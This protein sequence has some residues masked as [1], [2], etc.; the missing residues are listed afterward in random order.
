[1]LI[2]P[3]SRGEHFDGVGTINAVR[4]LLEYGWDK[5][6]PPLTHARRVLFRL[7]A[8]DDDPDYLFEFGGKGTIDEDLARRARAILREAAAAALAQAGYEGDPRL[9][10]AARRIIERVVALSALAAR[11]E[12]VRS[13]RQSARARR[14]GRAAVGLCCCSCS[15]T[16][17]SFA[18]SI[19]TRWRCSTTT[20]R[21]RS[22]DRKAM[23]LVRQEVV[24]QPHLVLGDMLPNRNAA[25][26]DVVFADH[27]ARADGA[28][29]LSP[30]E[31]QLVQAVRAVPRRPRRA[32]RL[33]SAQRHVGR[34]Q[35]ESVPLA[36]VS[37]RGSSRAATSAGPTSPS[38]SASSA[39]SLGRTIE[40]GVTRAAV[41]G[42]DVSGRHRTNIAVRF[43]DARRHERR[44]RIP[45]S[46]FSGDVDR[47]HAAR[48]G[49][50]AVHVPPRA[51]VAA[52]A[53]R[54]AASP[55]TSA[56]SGS[57]TSRAARDSYTLDAYVARSRRAARRARIAARGVDRTL[58]GRRDR[59]ALRAVDVPIASAD[60]C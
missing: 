28:A 8:E 5:D 54:R 59:A 25:D 17:R 38:D 31:R 3:S 32:R 13:R 51:R 60:S 20:S 36:D 2:V 45:E 42:R 50:V 16:C 23:Q 14:R 52:R 37:A 39:G 6:T 26:A 47:G 41:P 49:R 58:D 34:A 11:A 46:G 7:L 27:V 9:R 40:L 4:R 33:A 19:T 43:V 21:S 12:A 24:A 30:P 56:A 15:R 44:V 10:G 1:M 55:S 35:L 53:R 57:R 22:R 29:R 18:P 48:L